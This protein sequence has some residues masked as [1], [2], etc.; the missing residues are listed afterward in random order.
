MLVSLF[1]EGRPVHAIGDLYQTELGAFVT[2][3]FSD[4]YDSVSFHCKSID[5]I[6]AIGE[7]IVAAGKRLKVSSEELVPDRRIVMRPEE[8]AF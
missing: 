5:E 6:T 3:E 7:A 8:V 1:T 2:V 4:P